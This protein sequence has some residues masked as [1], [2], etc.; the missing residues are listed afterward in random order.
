MTALLPD[1]VIKVIENIKDKNTISKLGIMIQSGS[2]KHM[3][4]LI[5]F[6]VFVFLIIY[7]M[8]GRKGQTE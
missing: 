8:M 4:Y 3:Y 6:V 5:A 1:I 7:F 2:S